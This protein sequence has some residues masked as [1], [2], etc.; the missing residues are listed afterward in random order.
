MDSEIA[1]PDKETVGPELYE[2]LG[3]KWYEAGDDPIALLR[4]QHQLTNPWMLAEIRKNIGYRA[5]ILDIGCGPGFFANEAVKLG[6]KVTG[7]DIST[8]QLRVAQL[9]DATKSVRYIYGDAYAI[10]YPR[11]SFDVVMAMDLLEHVSDPQKVLFEASRVLRP[12]GLMFFHTF[13]RNFLSYL[14]VVKGVQW[15]VKNT[16][17]DLHVYQL[18][19]K[20]EEVEEWIDNAGMDLKVTRGLAPVLWQ[21]GWWQLLWN[22]VVPESFQFRWTKSRLVSYIGYAKKLREQ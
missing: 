5:E 9:R 17:A 15:F 13:N 20:P 12:G 3:K 11:E 1:R 6:H 16:P 18:F 19:R 4:H 22:R 7:I 2:Q 8:T 14:L 21:A 10:P